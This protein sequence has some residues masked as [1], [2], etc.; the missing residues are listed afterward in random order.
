M[1]KLFL[2]VAMAAVYLL[3]FAQGNNS[4]LSLTTKM[5]LRELNDG[6]FDP[7]KQATRRQA[8]M[9]RGEKSFIQSSK[10]E[11]R[12][13]ATP[14]TID[15]RAFISAFIRLDDS[16]N[17][18]AIEAI[19][20]QVQCRFPNGLITSNIPVDKFYEILDLDNVKEV[21]VASVMQSQTYESRNLTKDFDVLTLSNQAK[22]LGLNTAYTG[23]GVLLGVIDQGIDYRHIAFKDVEGKSRVKGAYCKKENYPPVWSEDK[24]F[25]N[26][27]HP[28]EDHGTH[29]ASIAGGSSVI[30]N[31][32]SVTVTNDHAK[33]SLGGM[34]PEADLYLCG[35]HGTYDTYAANCMYLICRY[36]D[37]HEMPVVVSNSW[38]NWWGPHDGSGDSKL[39]EVCNSLFSDD[40]PNH[41]CL[42]S[43]ANNAN[44]SKNNEGGGNHIM[45]IARHD[46]PL[47]TIIRKS[48]NSD[49]DCGYYYN[50][51]IACAWSRIS[52][53]EGMNCTVYVL[54]NDNG[55][56]LATIPVSA[57]DGVVS[58]LEEYY[59]GQLSVD[60]EEKGEKQGYIIKADNLTTKKYTEKNKTRK[61]KYT[62]AFDVYP[63]NG[64]AL[65][66]MWG[67][68]DCYLTNHLQSNGH[69]WTA[70]SD[71]MSVIDNATIPSVISVG[72]YIG[73]NGWIDYQ[74]GSWLRDDI[75]NNMIGDIV[76]F[77]SY[78]VAE[79]SP[80][81]EDYPWITAPGFHIA[82]A[83]N[84]FNTSGTYLSGDQKKRVNKDT[85][86]PY[87]V[88]DGT[89]MSTPM[90][91]GIVALWM[92]AAK[93]KGIKLTTSQV[94][95]IMKETAIRDDFTKGTN[96]KRFGNG[97]IDALAGINYIVNYKSIEASETSLTL[98]GEVD[99]TVEQTFHVR[100]T[101]GSD[102]VT[103]T[104]L[105]HDPDNVFTIDKPV[106][107]IGTEGVD[108]K[109]TWSPKAVGTSTATI[110]LST[111][112]ED[113]MIGDVVVNLEG[114][115]LAKPV[116]SVNTN[117]LTFTSKPNTS[118][119]RSLTVKGY[120]LRED[121]TLVLDDKSGVFSVNKTNIPVNS[122]DEPTTITVI[123]TP[124][125]A[126]YYAGTLTIESGNA[127][128]TVIGLYGSAGNSGTLARWEYWFDDETPGKNHIDLSGTEGEI[129]YDINTSKLSGGMHLLHTR[130]VQTGGE[131]SYSPVSTTLFFK[132]PEGT[133][134]QVEYWFG[135][136][137][138]APATIDL[139]A[140]DGESEE[141]VIDM[142]NAKTLPTGQHRLNIRVAS[143]GQAFGNIYSTPVMKM[144]NGKLDLLQYWIGKNGQKQTL[145]S[146]SG[147]EGV[148]IFDGDLKLS[149]VPIGLH[150]LNYRAI[151]SD[152][153]ASSMVY[154]TIIMK[155]GTGNIDK[156]EYW[157]DNDMSFKQEIPVTR[158]DDKGN[159]VFDGNMNLSSLPMG[160]H[161]VSY[162]AVSSSGNLSSIVYTT[163]VMKTG[164]G[165]LDILEYWV[166][167]DGQK[168]TLQSKTCSD[169]VS[170]FDGDLKLG[171]LP[172]G[173]H[174]LN[175]RA[176]SSDGTAS[177]TV[178]STIIM[179]SGT[180]NI[181][182]IEYWFDNDM[183]FK[184]EIPCTS[185]DENGNIIF[186]G[187]MNLNSLP[188]GLHSV[189]YRAAS[190]TGSLSS[191]VYTTMVMKMGTSGTDKLEYWFGDK[192]ENPKTI[193]SVARD[194]DGNYIFDSNLNFSN[195]PMGAHRLNYRALGSDGSVI[196]AVYTTTVFVRK[197]KTQKLE[198]W[199]DDD[200]GQLPPLE[201][202]GLLG[203]FTF[204]KTLDLSHLS[205]GAH[206]LYYRPVSSDGTLAGAI[207]STAIIA[208]SLYKSE[209][210]P[211]K[212]TGY[213]LSIDDGAPMYYHVLKPAWR[214]T[215]PYTLDARKMTAGE[216]QLNMRFWNSMGG[217]VSMTSS[218]TKKEIVPPSITLK[219]TEKDGQV[220]LS[221][222]SI[223]NDV[224]FRLYRVDGNGVKVSIAGKTGSSYPSAISYEDS[225][226]EGTYTYHAESIYT[227]PDGNRQRIIS[228]EV[229]VSISTPQ[230]EETVAE[231]YGYI[232][233]RIVCDKNTPTNGLIVAFSDGVTISAD[234]ASFL[235]MKLLAGKVLTLTVT[236]DDTHEYESQT[237][238]VKAGANF[239]TLRGIQVEGNQSDNLAND[240]C[241]SSDI[242]WTTDGGKNCAKFKV[243]NLSK[244]KTW[245]GLVRVKAIDKAK[246]DKK[247]YDLASLPYSNKNI[248]NLYSGDLEIAASA[249]AT[250]TIFT[251]GLAQSEDIEYYMFFESVGKWKGVDMD[252]ETKPVAV[253]DVVGMADNP[254]ARM[255]EKKVLIEDLWDEESMQKLANLLVRLSS[256]N[257]GLADKTGDLSRYRSDMVKMAKNVTGQSD[258]SK[259]IGGLMD[260]LDSKSVVEIVN[261]PK[262]LSG[263]SL[264]FDAGSDLIGK[265]PEKYWNGLMRQ[266]VN[267]ADAKFLVSEF[268]QVVKGMTGKD[269]Y[270]RAF[271]CANLLYAYIAQAASSSGA[272]NP[273]SAL[274]YSYLVVGKALCNKVMELGQILHDGYLSERL[275][276]NRP[277]TGER[278]G[279]NK[280]KYNTTCDFK[281]IVKSGKKKIDFTDVQMSRQVKRVCIKASN[282]SSQ[283]VA[284]IPFTCKFLYDGIM[285][286]SQ[287]R[288][289]IENAGGISA[290]LGTKLTEFYMEIEWDNER[291]T[292]IPLIEE[293]DGIDIHVGQR[294]EGLT[295]YETDLDQSVYTI[296]LTTASGKEH[297][298]DEL[299]LGTNKKR[300]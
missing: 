285:L 83:V 112:D 172:I 127:E 10:I 199:F 186:D 55:S 9:V 159:A 237:L 1:R 74:G 157:F 96:K 85:N 25:V 289:S 298:G 189:S 140:A 214:I 49:T 69:S 77:S 152:G 19:G 254:I 50:G 219:A 144:G 62:L 135:D 297:I 130:V 15:G 89:S 6:G 220:S 81:H 31:G 87:G 296:T 21:S 92:Q 215:Q 280:N 168:Q 139:S 105:L 16:N 218:F 32:E 267:V 196:S 108:V 79:Q 3:S 40:H 268:A 290:N 252:K 158:H 111:F 255:I 120:R 279:K 283:G 277:F 22:A 66:D 171:S 195:L 216:H 142:S 184:Q 247:N 203:T 134:K 52:C 260:L 178:Y 53:L 150:Q 287:G 263:V 206:R 175:Y 240:L 228:N 27:D 154:S 26:T 57:S 282:S 221:F 84:S 227:D 149:S 145:K 45:A 82:S 208:N 125:S 271:A 170:I 73:R 63:V 101:K 185:V 300:K 136:K 65:V 291:T 72:A 250:V 37:K 274:M 148:S 251:E 201:T 211:V 132:R 161:R 212:V 235:R 265:M 259:A 147:S 278:T 11:D 42:F 261:E 294:F 225:P 78:A 183:S 124:H 173:L 284:V 24:I 44:N 226:A 180:G 133:A 160:L 295:G 245:Q 275:Y 299:Y 143:N 33:A 110:T 30:F 86:N 162:R 95:N 107:V 122:L 116:I 202:S 80:T 213:S 155:S 187:D 119:S 131:Y 248:H 46:A 193:S 123:F 4:K 163:P 273:Y 90:V 272:A 270:E 23:K 204:D 91:A 166:G 121:A 5:F 181:D 71:D 165:K 232:S 281:V 200:R 238:T 137:Y 104:A 209:N 98:Y 207:S 197:G 68:R 194:K 106:M 102:K 174:Q 138:E 128:R 100:M 115:V 223:P 114:T 59:E 253:N 118:S 67:G 109:V 182:K 47:G 54:N 129:D 266:I 29:T 94:K 169:G 217:S 167:K 18:S 17:T 141:V 103:V 8:M 286:V 276:Q 234:N 198:Y 231:Q 12:C 13:Y 241:F 191:I 257:D 188:L 39:G 35:L 113:E 230:E 93:E 249:D 244:E 256:L 164:N 192:Y 146:I 61:S 264:L 288:E 43:S 292:K 177:S 28:T 222:N 88:M 41:I 262:L 153:M 156:I 38:G 56:V 99:E 229:T 2:I 7:A 14:D 117:K 20:V 293:A 233:G 126:G 176:V 60:Y 224:S 239:V 243:Q 258:E 97:K 70:G 236:G 36:A 205:P 58:G 210:N 269:E 242:E 76:P 246:A 48:S 75:S 151:S 51:V 64:S 190:S 179:K 34:A